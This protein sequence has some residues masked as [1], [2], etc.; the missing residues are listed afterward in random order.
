MDR[1]F[2][3]YE[4]W[5]FANAKEHTANHFRDWALNH[6]TPGPASAKIELLDSVPE[7]SM[8]M[9]LS[10]RVRAQNL[11]NTIWQF[12]PGTATGIHV[13]YTVFTPDRKVWGQHRAGNINSRVLPGE[14]IELRLP[15]PPFVI[16][17]T[18]MVQV[19][20]SDKHL[21]FSQMSSELLEFDI[22]VRPDARRP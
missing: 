16:P 5:L 19:D 4:E 18:Y 17:G 1:F 7:I 21:S 12:R 20:L 13:R 10:I 14:A 22:V 15:F 6:Y 11:S 8:G 9:P 2:D 3:M